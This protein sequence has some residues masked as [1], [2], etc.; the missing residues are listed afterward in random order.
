MTLS[1]EYILNH[2]NTQDKYWLDLIRSEFSTN[3]QETQFLNF[4]L[5][6]HEYIVDTIKKINIQC[7]DINIRSIQISLLRG[8]LIKSIKQS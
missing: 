4:V 6:F 7:L 3:S 8:G 1:I 2:F 5:P